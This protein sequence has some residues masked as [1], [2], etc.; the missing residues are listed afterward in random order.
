MEIWP[1]RFLKEYPGTQKQLLSASC[2]QPAGYATR[3]PGQQK[4][5][6]IWPSRFLKNLEA[7]AS[8]KETG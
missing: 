8:D 4:V 2:S 1:S 7:G 3:I 5:V 6:E